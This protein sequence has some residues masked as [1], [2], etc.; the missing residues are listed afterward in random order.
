MW[1][2]LNK[3]PDARSARAFELV[4]VAPDT[5][6]S[7]AAEK[8]IELLE[9]DHRNSR[10]HGIS[11][12]TLATILKLPDSGKVVHD[13]Q[14]DLDRVPPGWYFNPEWRDFR[15]RRW[16]PCDDRKLAQCPLILKYARAWDDGAVASFVMEGSLL[17]LRPGVRPQ[18]IVGIKSGNRLSQFRLHQL[19]SPEKHAP[20]ELSLVPAVRQQESEEP[21]TASD[22][23]WH[24]DWRTPR[25]AL[26]REPYCDPDK[27]VE[28]DGLN[29]V[30]D[31]LK[32][33]FVDSPVSAW[34]SWATEICDGKPHTDFELL[35]LFA[36]A[37]MAL[38]ALL[39]WR[40]Q[41]RKSESIQSGPA[42]LAALMR[43]LLAWTDSTRAAQFPG[44]EWTP[45][46]E[47]L[48]IKT[49]QIEI[50]DRITVRRGFDAEQLM[51]LQLVVPEER[52]V[53]PL[54][55]DVTRL[56]GMLLA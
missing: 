37:A 32:L 10:I 55:L 22:R 2:V 26:G 38:P 27:I 9:V 11:A 3:S 15:I 6:A 42:A 7:D 23:Y 17:S 25:F 44:I 36:A 13:L 24:G 48:G 31:L 21:A 51:A 35:S 43:I 50:S 56:E 12:S 41:F 40:K 29:P 8:E 20:T 28:N 45:E 46:F 33:C 30:S 52:L 49:D 14:V 18:L 19:R 1:Q 34:R 39:Y 4:E 53:T 54:I 5:I 16:K 47:A